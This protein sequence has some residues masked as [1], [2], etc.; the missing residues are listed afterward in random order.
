MEQGEKLANPMRHYCNPSAVLA[1]EE[2]TKEDRIIALKNW[3]DDIHLKLVATEENMG[4]TSCDVTL[5]AEI[6]NLL[7]FLEHE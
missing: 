6:D 7:N 4:P 2:L 5:V 1:D 3:R